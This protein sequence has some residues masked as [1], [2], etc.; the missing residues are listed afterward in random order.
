MIM[1]DLIDALS[2]A[3]ALLVIF[4]PIA[5]VGYNILTKEDKHDEGN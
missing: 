1:N 3:L 5:K 4:G 2:F